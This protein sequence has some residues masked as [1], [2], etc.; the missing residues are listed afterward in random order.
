MHG[1]PAGSAHARYADHR[2][3]YIA[4]A[5][6]RYAE[7]VAPARRARATR[8]L[9]CPVCGTAFETTN[10]VKRYCAASCRQQRITGRVAYARDAPAS[11][12]G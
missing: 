12:S 3:R 9:T 7:V 2:D 8:R 10:D 6:R 1:G 11:H 4:N 5:T